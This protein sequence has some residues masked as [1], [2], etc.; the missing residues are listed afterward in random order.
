MMS[1]CRLPSTATVD[2]EVFADTCSFEVRA[3]ALFL[4]VLTLIILQRFP[5]RAFHY[6]MD[7]IFAEGRLRLR[8]TQHTLTA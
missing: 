5:E 8:R 2:D 3:C 7:G 1:K 4:V 6:S